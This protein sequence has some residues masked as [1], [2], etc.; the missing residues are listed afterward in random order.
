MVACA[1]CSKAADTGRLDCS[2]CN[3]SFHYQC[4]GYADSTY[5]KMGADKRSKWLC[6]ICKSKNSSTPLPGE[7]MG[8]KEYFDMKFNLLN[9]VI[10]DQKE[11]VINALNLKVKALEENLSMKDEKIAELEDRMDMLENRSRMA[12]I[13]IRNM[14]E[15]PNEDVMLIVE[16]I[17]RTIGI[18]D[19][20][21]GDI[22]VAHRV[23]NRDGSKGNRPIVA[24]LSS[25]YM[26]NK[27]LQ[28][29]KDHKK[30]K[31]NLTAKKVNGNLPEVNIGMYEHITVEKKLLLKE[32]H[33]FAREKQIKFVWVK[34]ALILIKKN[35]MDRR[36]IKI[37]TK[38]EFESLK[39]EM[40][41]NFQNV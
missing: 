26:R 20:R 10:A 40:N 37:G 34:D 11:E 30:E 33:E 32:I 22:Q 4:A 8:M 15:T 23:N 18:L 27:W 35:E 31:G 7:E 14:P 19:I 17:G 24:H 12:N 28:N 29:F 13:E 38:R 3:K 41:Q 6:T 25:R 9:Q 2:G 39:A 16:E 21:D 1:K 36:V 5:S